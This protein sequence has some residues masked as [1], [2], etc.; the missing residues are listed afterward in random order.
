MKSEKEAEPRI[1]TEL[2]GKDQEK[3]PFICRLTH[4]FLSE[5]DA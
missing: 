5:P 2:H 3:G 4:N 1:N